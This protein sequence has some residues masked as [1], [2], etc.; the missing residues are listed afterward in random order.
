MFWDGEIRSVFE[1]KWMLTEMQ[2]IPRDSLMAA[3]AYIDFSN[4]DNSRAWFGCNQIFWSTKKKKNHKLQLSPA[5]TTEIYCVHKQ[6]METLFLTIQKNII[7]YKLE[8][9]FIY[10]YG[11]NN[12]LLIK[13]VNPAWD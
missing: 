4:L 11:K 10:L 1:S 5:V 9:H 3:E 12:E 7:H 13:A 2:E 8:G 6:H